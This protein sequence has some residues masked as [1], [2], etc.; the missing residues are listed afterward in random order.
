MS[1]RKFR[2]FTLLVSLALTS[3]MACKKG[4]D[5][6]GGEGGE[7]ESDCPAGALTVNGE[8][9]EFQTGFGYQERGE[10]ALELYNHEELNCEIIL[11]RAARTVPDGEIDLRMATVFG[12]MVASGSE[13][14][15]GVSIALEVEPSDAGDTIAF[16]IDEPVEIAEGITAQG[17]FSGDYCGAVGQ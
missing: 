10:F 7:A 15:M 1:A 11:A 3:A 13:H 5:D 12:G 17:L 4:G 16:C 14:Q 6:E 2:L 8:A 9:V